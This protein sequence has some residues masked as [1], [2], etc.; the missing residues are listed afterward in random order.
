MFAESDKEFFDYNFFIINSENYKYQSSRL[1]GY[2]LF[3]N[4]IYINGVVKNIPSNA[5]GAF[6]NIDCQER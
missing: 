3:E 5:D 4:N 1:Y 2:T 6:I